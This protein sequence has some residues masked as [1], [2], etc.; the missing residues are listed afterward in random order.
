MYIKT[1]NAPGPYSLKQSN[2][3]DVVIN[4]AMPV[5]FPVKADIPPDGTAKAG[6]LT[7]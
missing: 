3:R 1:H 4:A 6:A 7:W 5:G 2:S